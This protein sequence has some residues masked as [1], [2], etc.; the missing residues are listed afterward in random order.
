MERIPCPHCGPRPLAEFSYGG[1]VVP[2]P[3]PEP[4]DDATWGAYLYVRSNPKGP[5]SERWVHIHGCRRWFTLTRDT[6][7]HR[8]LDTPLRKEEA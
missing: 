6:A 3:D 4:A 7:T 1:E 8:I 5:Q 2:R